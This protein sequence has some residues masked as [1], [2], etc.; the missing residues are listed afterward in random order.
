MVARRALLLSAGALLCRP[1]SAQAAELRIGASAALSGPAAQLGQRFHAGARALFEQLNQQGGLH[2]ARLVLDLRDDGYEPAR[3]EANSR[4]LMEDE[5]VLAL[6]GYVGTPTSRAA[7]PYARRGRMAFVGPF[8]GAGF[9]Y[10]PALAHVFMV[11]AGYESEGRVLAAAMRREGVQRVNVLY[12]ADLFGRSGLEALRQAAQQLEL[13]LGM[14]A[15]V[16]RNSR[17][18]DKALQLLVHDSPAPAI[19]LVSTYDTC[20]SFVKAARQAGYKG[21]FYTL[22]FA[23]LEPLRAALGRESRGVAITQVVPDPEDRS[24]PVV[25]AYQRAMSEAGETQL[26]SISLEGYLAARVL[27]EGLRRAR[28]PLSRTGLLHSLSGLGELDLGGFSLRYLP[29]GRRGASHV[30]LR[31]LGR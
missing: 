10:D 15:T 5:R 28:P 18:I 11:R 8:T 23:G 24:L 27:V 21:R 7:M 22:S 20:A 14:T 9:L 2:G 16:R 31:S 6:F 1:V 19:F 13:P 12:Q 25:A 26:D 29:D 30:S 3:A 4:A 17:D